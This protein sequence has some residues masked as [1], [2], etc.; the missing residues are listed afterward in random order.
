MTVK[1]I[2]QDNLQALREESYRVETEALAVTRQAQLYAHDIE[3]I[4]DDQFDSSSGS[5]S[6]SLGYLEESLDIL[7][8]RVVN[9][10]DA[11]KATLY[12]LK[13]DALEE[14][15]NNSLEK[16]SSF[17]DKNFE[18]NLHSTIIRLQATLSAS[19]DLI[20]EVDD[21]KVVT[22]YDNLKEKIE[23]QI[24]QFLGELESILNNSTKPKS[25]NKQ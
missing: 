2:F 8:R 13:R 11:D 7:D 10:S 24:L 1:N 3:E 19:D 4:S 25:K 20:G 22:A 16:L 17:I 6:D 5:L 18:K 23:K 15:L 9:S 21:E 14:D 12:N